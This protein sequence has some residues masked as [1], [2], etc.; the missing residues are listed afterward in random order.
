[1][2]LFIVIRMFLQTDFGVRIGI[3]MAKQK[4]TVPGDGRYII[5]DG[6][7]GTGKTPLVRD[8]RSYCFKQYGINNNVVI[9]EPYLTET[10]ATLTLVGSWQEAMDLLYQDRLKLQKFI[11]SLSPDDLIIADRGL[12]STYVYQ[13]YLANKYYP[14]LETV[15]NPEVDLQVRLDMIYQQY[16]NCAYYKEAHYIVLMPSE[17]IMAERL[18]IQRRAKDLHS[19]DPVSLSDLRQELGAWEAFIAG[20]FSRPL[21]KNLYIV[22]IK[23]NDCVSK[24]NTVVKEL[25]ETI[26]QKESL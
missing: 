9:R 10:R 1:V 14:N 21:C 4:K 8:L 18:K 5:L 3:D 22:P 26:L 7:N 24:L 2:A 13:G 23:T 15:I 6:P 20:N 25:V 16:E 17:D 11:N 19:F 12:L